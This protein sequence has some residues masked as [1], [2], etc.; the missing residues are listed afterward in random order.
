MCVNRNLGPTYEIDTFTNKERNATWGAETQR[1]DDR[2]ELTSR[3]H[4]LIVD[5]K[6]V[7]IDN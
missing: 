1:S 7:G 2:L 5:E 6:K 3:M 4:W